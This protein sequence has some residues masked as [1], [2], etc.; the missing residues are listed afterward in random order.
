MGELIAIASSGYP[1]GS[2]EQYWE[3][4]QAG[5]DPY[6]GDT[7]AAFIAI[8]LSETFDPDASDCEQR[9]EACRVLGNACNELSGAYAAL[10]AGQTTHRDEEDDDANT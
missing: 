10:L 2:V 1:D 9:G 6:V 5:K 3:A 7:L 8:E 4:K